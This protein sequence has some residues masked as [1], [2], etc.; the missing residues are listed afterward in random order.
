MSPLEMIEEIL[1]IL[2]RRWRLIARVTLLGVFAA[3]VFALQSP[4][5]YQSFEVIHMSSRETV[6]RSTISVIASPTSGSLP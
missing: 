4:R 2:R 3:A 6:P 1:D 5:V